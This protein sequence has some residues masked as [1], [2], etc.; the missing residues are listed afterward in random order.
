[1]LLLLSAVSSDPGFFMKP[2]SIAALLGSPEL[3]LL[4]WVLAGVFT[5]TGALIFA[6][7][8]A[9]LPVTG[10][11]Y[12]FF[13]YIFGDFL[14]YLYGWAAFAVINTAGVAAIVFVCAIYANHFLHLPEMDPALVASWKLHLPFIGDFYL[15]DKLGIKL[16][17]IGIVIIL[18]WLNVRSLKAGSSFQVV[19]TA[20]KLFVIGALVVGIFCSGSG[21]TQNWMQNSIVADNNNLLSGI[22]L[23]LTGAFFAYDGWANLTFVAG[24]IKDPR[25][26][27]PRMLFAGVLVCIIVYILT[28]LA[29]LYVLPIDQMAASPLVASDAASAAWGR[30]SGDIVAAM[31]VICTLGAVNGNILACSRVTYAMSRDGLFPSWA[32]K[33]NP[34]ARTP[35]NALW[36]HAI[37]TCGFI[38]TGTFD[39]LADMFIFITWIAYSLGAVGLFVMRKKNPPAN[40]LTVSGVIQFCQRCLSSSIFSILYQPLFL[41]SKTTHRAGNR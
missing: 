4:V 32:G 10:G 25:K 14:A 8:G 12:A 38:F 37:W 17:A 13:R 5:L 30:L 11:V 21:S 31:I 41:M 20:L 7:L 22:V 33:E 19:S 29:Y 3:M 24:E 28:N 2:A 40:A 15:L 27:I 23:A 6:E 36:L 9:M 18:T 35:V 16:L 39:M 1:M 34:K 26:N